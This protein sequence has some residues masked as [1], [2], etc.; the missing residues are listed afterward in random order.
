MEQVNPLVRMRLTHP[1]ELSLHLL[2]RMLFQVG[3]NEEQFVCERGQWTGVIRTIAATCAGVSSDRA[4]LPV[5]D[6]RPLESG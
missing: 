5:G 4:V 3:Q 6:K 1:E 2:N